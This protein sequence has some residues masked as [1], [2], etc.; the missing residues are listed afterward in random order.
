MVEMKSQQSLIKIGV[1]RLRSS[2]GFTRTKL[3]L[4]PSMQ[5]ILTLKHPMNKTNA[6]ITDFFIFASLYKYNESYINVRL[7]SE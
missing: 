6:N 5:L 7:N 3:G 1:P 4:R 2:P